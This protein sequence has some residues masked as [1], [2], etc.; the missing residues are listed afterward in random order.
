MPVSEPELLIALIPYMFFPGWT[1][2]DEGEYDVKVVVFLSSYEPV[3]GL[4]LYTSYE[5]GLPH[6]ELDGLVHVTV[7]D[8]VPL[9]FTVG[10]QGEYSVLPPP[11]L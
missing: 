7:C 2:E 5:V 8:E 6:P 10:G 4:R 11:S 1:S 3:L 9:T